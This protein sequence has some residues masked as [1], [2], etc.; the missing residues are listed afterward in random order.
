VMTPEE[1]QLLLERLVN[2]LQRG[3]ISVEL[4]NWFP[5]QPQPVGDAGA[6]AGVDGHRTSAGYEAA[7]SVWLYWWLWQQPISSVSDLERV[8]D[9]F[10]D[11]V[12]A[13]EGK[14]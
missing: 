8:V 3:L 1:R 5:G 4:V 14:T 10:C 7:D 12:L 6:S 13:V 2:A 9:R 11:V